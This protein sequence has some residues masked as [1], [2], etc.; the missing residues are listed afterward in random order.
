[1]EIVCL[2][3]AAVIGGLVVYLIQRPAIGAKDK[4]IVDAEK[5][6]SALE[7]QRNTLQGEIGR[8]TS[9]HEKACRALEEKLAAVK[10]ENEQ[11][12]VDQA[13]KDEALE[14]E[15]KRIADMTRHYQ[16]TKDAAKAEFETLSQKILDERSA[17]L[18]TEGNEQLK[19]VVDG[20]A[21]DI[22]AFQDK[23]AASDVESARNNTSLQEKIAQLVGQTNA[24]TAQACNLADAIRGEAQLTGEWGEIQLKRVLE[25]AG[26]HEGSGFTY[27]ETFID[28]EGKRKRTDFIVKMPGGRSLII[29]SK[30]TVQSALDY[31]AAKTKDEKAAALK[32]IIASV[33]THIAEI[34]DARY[35]GAVPNS[36][37]TVLMY[38]PVDEVYILAMKSKLSAQNST[39]LVREYAA[40]NNIVI[41]NSASVVPA[42]RLIQ[43]MWADDAASQNAKEIVKAAQELLRRCN[44]FV[45]N[46]L[47]I[48][49]KLV[50][51]RDVYDNVKAKLIHAPGAQSI[52][53][54]VENL[55]SLGVAP[56]TR[57]GKSKALKK[58]ICDESS[59]PVADG[60][61]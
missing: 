22:K 18:K 55:V 61:A 8:Q 33:E 43:M 25:S 23:I 54:A 13:R 19:G 57:G 10:D 14:S 51:V 34:I 58:V 49:E 12:K 41:V 56:E 44:A 6:V 46:F 11:L 24:V 21:K 31:H 27:Q 3:F 26:M 36:F 15:R 17:K 39:E 35:P 52:P 9:E 29:D 16:E 4:R 42:V 45:E 60:I 32:S 5:S 28:P 48:G 59:D 53:K 7:A 50:E 37:P 30:A 47:T 1:M 2:V 38:I 20:L 40:R